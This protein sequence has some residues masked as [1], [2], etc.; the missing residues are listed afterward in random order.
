MKAAHLK[1]NLWEFCSVLGGGMFLLFARGADWFNHNQSAYFIYG[2]RLFDP[3][4]IPKDWFTW[5]T[6]H[7]DFAFAHLLAGLL[8]LGPLHTVVMVVHI[9]LLA[10]LAYALLILCRRFFAHPFVVYCL[11]LAWVGVVNTGEAGLGG[12]NLYFG[13]FQPSEVAGC[14]MM[15]G[16]I[17]LLDHRYLLSGIILGFAGI[18]HGS[19]LVSTAPAVLI[20]AWVCGAFNSKR[21]LLAFGLPLGVLWGM[22]FFI[23]LNA[24]SHS[25][26]ASAKTMG[27]MLHLR[28]SGDFEFSQWPLQATFNWFVWAF[29]GLTAISQFPMEQK[30][31]EFRACFLALLITSLFAIAQL[32]LVDHASVTMLML[33]RSSSFVLILGVAAIIGRCVQILIYPKAITNKDR[34]FIAGCIIAAIVFMNNQWGIS[35][36]RRFLWMMIFPMAAGAAWFGK[37]RLVK[38]LIIAMVLAI[39]LRTSSQGI[40]TANN[41]ETHPEPPLVGEMEKWVK[42]RT[43]KDSIFAVPI[44]M[45]HMRIRGKR[46]IVADW[47][48]SCYLP[49]DLQHWYERICDLS[50]L[51]SNV[52][53]SDYQAFVDGYDRLN[54]SR[55]KK[56]KE[57][58]GV[59]YV[60]VFSRRH[61]GNLD[62]LI[63]RYANAD[64]K[65]LEVPN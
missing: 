52:L 33:W 5:Q 46:A 9:I 23:M 14:L 63:E 29:L 44:D 12:Q 16:L 50:G 15:I 13:F 6:F 36:N 34:I 58:Y 64:Y 49:S 37:P 7:H 61:K 30:Y 32:I 40:K 4:F 43:P 59:D 18:F 65:V 1:L 55:A 20:T 24:M 22:F 47:A 51:P 38:G 3:T 62:G 42:E 54:L 8:R 19:F 48:S 41:F 10:G 26:P 53:Y 56:L 57:R 27:M 45:P 17:F 21:N 31:K 2:T 60:V 28:G 39:A 11:L 25:A 35:S